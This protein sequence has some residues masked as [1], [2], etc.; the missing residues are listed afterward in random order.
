MYRYQ[1]GEPPTRVAHEDEQPDERDDPVHHDGEAVDDEPEQEDDEPEHQRHRDADRQLRGL[2][3]GEREAL[4]VR[5]LFV[6]QTLADAAAGLDELT[7]GDSPGAF[8][9]A[10]LEYVRRPDERRPRLA[11]RRPHRLLRLR[12]RAALRLPLGRAQP[13]G[14][15]SGSSPLPHREWRSRTRPRTPSRVPRCPGCRR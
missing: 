4:H 14:R 1:R 13:P 5:V 3:R 10:Y 15:R 8:A 12:Q 7:E 11:P 9:R 2:G 6:E